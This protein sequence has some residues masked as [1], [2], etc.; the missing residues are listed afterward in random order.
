M[1]SDSS[2]KSI[3]DITISSHGG[4]ANTVIIYDGGTIRLD[5]VHI[6]AITA[7]DFVF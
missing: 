5:G 7:A 4:G 2:I 3:N 6:S 1:F